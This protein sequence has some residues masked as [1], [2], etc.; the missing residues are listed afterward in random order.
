MKKEIIIH[1]PEEMIAFGKKL[2]EELTSNM[3]ITMKGDLG[4]GK[5]TMTKGIALGLGINQIV[6]SP[7]FTLLKIYHGR[8]D[9]YHMDV[10]RITNAMD[11]FELEEYFEAGGV[12][13]IEW[14]DQIQELLPQERLNIEIY[15]DQEKRRVVLS[16]LSS[17]Y[18]NI[19]KKVIS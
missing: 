11:D 12:C 8:L 9:L 5:T 17:S 15:H 1:T 6:N 7:T 13:V 18:I 14:A 4:A 16:S 2:G 19:I 3:V 10:Y